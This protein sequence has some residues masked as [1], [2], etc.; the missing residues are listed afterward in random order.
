MNNNKNVIA[1][2]TSKK[3]VAKAKRSAEGGGNLTDEAPVHMYCNCLADPNGT[4]ACRMPD[5]I[6]APSTPA[7]YV[8]E[9]TLDSNANGDIA[10]SISP[11]LIRE[12]YSVTVTSG[13]VASTAYY[14]APDYAGITAACEYGRLV[15][16]EVQV[17][18]IGSAQ[19]AS[20]RF[21]MV[22]DGSLNNLTVGIALDTLFDDGPSVPA[23]D[24]I[25]TIMRPKGLPAYDVLTSPAFGVPNFDYLHFAARGLPI[26][27]AGVV[28]V[29]IIKHLE[30]LPMKGSVWRGSVSAEPYHP[31]AVAQ[32]ANM[33]AVGAAGSITARP[34]LVQDA[35]QAAKHAWNYI[36][37]EMQKAK[38]AAAIA[39][40]TYAKGKLMELLAAAA[41]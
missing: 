41:A 37:P 33:G 15:V 36:Q 8:S 38:G 39:L 16:Y 40:S 26:S 35:V 2:A 32:A 30:V 18:Y 27:A 28:S 4:M 12:K 14:P 11:S 21:T 19:L 1:T 3:N 7:K 9:F 34:S 24:G 13:A 5:T 10:F 17:N 25:F 23:Q 6:V 22:P 20:G 31:G 29:R